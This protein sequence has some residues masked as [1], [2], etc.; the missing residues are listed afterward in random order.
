MNKSSASNTPKQSARLKLKAVVRRLV[1]AEVADSWKG[2]GD[3]SDI[4]AIE[5]E[6]KQAKGAL[7]RAIDR[8]I[9][10]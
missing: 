4:P 3:P 10:L 1:R 9:P 6:L 7:D 2:G 8:V 5:Q